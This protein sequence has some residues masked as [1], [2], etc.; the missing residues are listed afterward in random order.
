MPQKE[1]I[2]ILSGSYSVNAGLEGIDVDRNHAK[3]GGGIMA[4]PSLASPVS[5]CSRR[6]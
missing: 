6:S 5:I 4:E 1:I 3:V 2:R